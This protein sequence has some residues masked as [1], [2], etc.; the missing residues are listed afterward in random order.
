MIIGLLLTIQNNYQNAKF[1]NNKIILTHLNK[2][3]DAICHG[4][5][6]NSKTWKI[7]IIAFIC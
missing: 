4:G 5:W 7:D 6:T 1:E 3:K 2:C